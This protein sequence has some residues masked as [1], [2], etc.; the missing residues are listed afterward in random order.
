[1]IRNIISR[2]ICSMVDSLFS[3]AAL[4]SIINVVRIEP[5][6]QP[7]L[8]SRHLELCADVLGQQSGNLHFHEI[9]QNEVSVPSQT[10]LL[11][12]SSELCGSSGLQIQENMF[13]FM[14]SWATWRCVR[15]KSSCASVGA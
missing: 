1:M 7:P 5:R 2:S 15:I 10:I 3:C 11:E 8:D 9:T 4:D 13:M 14:F 6:I 12:P